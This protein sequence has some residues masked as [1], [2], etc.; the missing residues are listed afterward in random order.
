MVR[1]LIP[2][3]GVEITE[4]HPSIEGEEV[5]GAVRK[6]CQQGPKMELRVSQLKRSYRG[7][8]KA[9]VLLEEA[10]A[11]KLLKVA[12]IKIGWFDFG[13]MVADCRGPDRSRSR[14]KCG[15]KGTLRGSAQGARGFTSAPL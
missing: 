7:V 8:S 13:H 2:R 4:L 15:D 11:L 14:W 3:I 5:E 6:F 9:Y 1:N 10:R 12:H